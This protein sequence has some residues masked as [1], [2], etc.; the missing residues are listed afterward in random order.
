[1]Y[2]MMAIAAELPTQEIISVNIWQILISLAN[3][4][5]LFLILKRFL[6]KPVQKMLAARQKTLDDTVRSANDAQ[7]NAQA[8]RERWAEKLANADSEADARINDAKSAAKTEGEKIVAR[9]KADAEAMMRSAKEEIALEQRRSEERMKLEIA[10]LSTQLA[11]K[12]LEREISPDDHRQLIDSFI[13][14]IGEQSGQSGDSG[15]SGE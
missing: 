6:Y 3:L 9:A 15:E 7:K 1:M 13:G 5:I 12:L 10:D 4:L 8:D 14:E 2:M 11:G